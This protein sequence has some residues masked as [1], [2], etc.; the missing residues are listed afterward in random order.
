MFI[1][2][3]KYNN[4]EFSAQYD[5]TIGPRCTCCQKAQHSELCQP[6]SVAGLTHADS[7]LVNL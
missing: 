7:A 5:S 3:L 6:Q 1:Y 2:T 4:G